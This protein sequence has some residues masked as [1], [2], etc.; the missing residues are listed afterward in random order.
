MFICPI[1][2]LQKALDAKQKCAFHQARVHVKQ[3]YS[4]TSVSLTITSMVKLQEEKK[5]KQY[6]KCSHVLSSFT[7]HQ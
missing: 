1:P 2:I 7:L 3:N 6:E 5:K 4:T